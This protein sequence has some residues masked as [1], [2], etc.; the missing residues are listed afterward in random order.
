MREPAAPDSRFPVTEAQFRS[1]MGE[2][3]SLEVAGKEGR[4]YLA[5][6]Q[7]LEGA[8][9]GTYPTQKYFTSPLALFAVP[10]AGSPDRLLRAVAIQ[11]TQQPGASNPIF[12]P[13]DGLGWQVARL[14]VQVA[15]GYY[16]EMIS[17]LGLT[18]LLVEAFVMATVR[19]LVPEHP[20]NVLLE[21]VELEVRLNERECAPALEAG[22]GSSGLGL[23]GPPSYRAIWR[24]GSSR[25]PASAPDEP[26]SGMGDPPSVAGGTVPPS[27][28][29]FQMAS[30][31]EETPG[32]ALIHRPPSSGVS[33]SMG[34]SGCSSRSRRRIRPSVLMAYLMPE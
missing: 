29:G 9:A 21:V 27:R 33:G 24:I 10:K 30:N 16:H 34:R 7:V 13:K 19:Q 26:P 5:D 23:R 1:V 6:Y 22:D 14:F 18:H 8:Q 28:G 25:H 3:D 2:D 32:S 15:D 4:L 11:C 20:L 17:H 31:S 12:T